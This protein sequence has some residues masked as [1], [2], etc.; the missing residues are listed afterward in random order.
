MAASQQTKELLQ[1][2]ESFLQ[3]TGM[4]V[5]YLGLAGANN[6]HL[7]ARLRRGG[8]IETRTAKRLREFMHQRLLELAQ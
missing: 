8:D 5:T 3:R 7:V 6:G 2:I 1:E 4:G